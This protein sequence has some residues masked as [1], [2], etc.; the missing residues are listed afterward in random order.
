[1]KLRPYS[2][3]V[4]ALGGVILAFV[5]PWGIALG[6]YGTERGVS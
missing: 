6:L 5:L 4:L 2:A 3:A 1:M